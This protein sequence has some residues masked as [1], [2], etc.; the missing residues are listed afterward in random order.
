MVAATKIKAITVMVSINSI[1]LFTSSNF[2]NR[3]SSFELV[4]FITSSRPHVKLFLEKKSTN[5]V[6]SHET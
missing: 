5:V 6:Y 4:L 2:L 1:I 3:V